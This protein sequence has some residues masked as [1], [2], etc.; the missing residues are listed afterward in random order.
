VD[1]EL[2]ALIDAALERGVGS[3]AALSVGDAGVEVVRIALGKTRSVP[4]PGAPIGDTA[5]FD[6]ASLTKPMATAAIAMA[7]VSEERLDLDASVQHWLPAVPD[8]RITVAHL[9]GHAAGY[10]AHRTIYERIWAGDLGGAATARQALIDL[11]SAE[12][13]ESEPGA[14]S[15]YSDLGYITLGA[16]CEQICG[17]RLD[18]LF[19]HLVAG[20]L[21]LHGAHFVD[22]TVPDAEH[23]HVATPI[24]ATEIDARRGLVAGEVHD[25]NSH[26]AGGITGHA[27]LF[28]TI[29]DVARFA[30]A[31]LDLGAG[32]DR[33][34]FHGAVA[35]HFFATAAAPGSS[36]RLGWDTPSATAGVSH[37]GDLWPRTGGIGHL[38]FTGT[39]LWLDLPRH[40]WVALLTN[41]V[42]PS[43]HGAAAAAIKELRR[44]VGDTVVRGLDRR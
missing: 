21:R 44:A 42:H 18:E 40:R 27:G 16:L 23:P 1:A 26:A 33:E 43:R 39:S 38:G 10:P 29:G 2:H 20:P 32:H 31:M 25:E 12:P 8:H 35:R 19:E 15:T 7:L 5:T 24:V 3:A 17:A 22:L 41:R 30:A 13:L 4:D 6:V 11:A 14:G 36:W 37:A 34:P 9:L 28:A